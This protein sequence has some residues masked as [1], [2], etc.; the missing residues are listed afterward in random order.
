MILNNLSKV[1]LFA[2]DEET[3]EFSGVEMKDVEWVHAN[4][5]AAYER[6]LFYYP[7]RIYLYSIFWYAI[8]GVYDKV[9]M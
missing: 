6:T 5:D 1:A 4:E 2:I 9:Y 3:C 7:L 8:V